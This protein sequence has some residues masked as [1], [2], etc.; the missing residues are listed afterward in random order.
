MLRVSGK[1]ILP[2]SILAHLERWALPVGRHIGS[3]RALVSILAHLERW[4]LLRV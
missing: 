3:H 1:R 2:V 4:A